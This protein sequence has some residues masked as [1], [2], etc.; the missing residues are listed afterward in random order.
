MRRKYYDK[1]IWV[2]MVGMLA[3][4]FQLSLFLYIKKNFGEGL[5][6]GLNA[7]V[8]GMICAAWFMS[9]LLR[10]FHEIDEQEF[11]A[12]AQV[13]S[14]KTAQHEAEQSEVIGIGAVVFP[15]TTKA[16]RAASMAASKFW[17]TYDRER[18]P[19]QKTVQGYLTDHGIPARQAVELASA[20]KPDSM[21]DA[22]DASDALV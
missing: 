1:T 13:K 2:F 22:S 21:S 10:N 18:P 9:F 17:I 8:F 4:A 14:T 6:W 16:L 7:G 15:Y 20:I 12:D 11:G 3:G 5:A 19:L